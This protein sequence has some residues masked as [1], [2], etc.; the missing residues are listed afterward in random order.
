VVDVRRAKAA[1]A[2]ALAKVA[3][4]TFPLACP[5]GSEPEDIAAF[6]AENLSVERFTEYL[7]DPG[8][9]LVV[10]E[11]DSDRSEFIGYTMLVAGEPADG[12]VSSA[13][14]LRPTIELSKVYVL[15]QHHGGGVARALVESTIAAAL[16]TDA[17]GIWLGVNDQNAR[18]VRFY[19]K[20]GF[21]RVGRKTFALGASLQSDYVM[22][23]PLRGA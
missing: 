18:A 14:R 9:V 5:P 3:A 8:R 23:R 1:D 12:D 13:V 11:S 6:I 2:G 7:A 16:D 15:E 4:E 21:E 19:E 22:E 10:A 17:T 20:A